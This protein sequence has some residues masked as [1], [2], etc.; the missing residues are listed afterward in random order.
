MEQPENFEN[1]LKENT[2]ITLHRDPATGKQNLQIPVPDEKTIG[3][4][5]QTMTELL[6]LFPLQPPTPP[7]ESSKS[8]K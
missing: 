5:F 7:L 4:I 2:G 3:R 1:V 8:K 6:S